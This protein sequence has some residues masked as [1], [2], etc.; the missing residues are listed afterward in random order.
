MTLVLLDS[1]EKQVSGTRPI[2]VELNGSQGEKELVDLVLFN[3]SQRYRYRQ[4]KF[5]LDV[6]SPV[7][8]ELSE[9]SWPELGPGAR[10]KF[11]VTV[12][13]PKRTETDLIINRVK[14]DALQ[15]PARRRL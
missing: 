3:E 1:D 12:S 11:T 2:D 5:S 15:Y 6:E 9:T 13:V 14:V 7:E 10:H 4:I 8:A